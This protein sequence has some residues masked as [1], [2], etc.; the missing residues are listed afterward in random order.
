MCLRLGS[1]KLLDQLISTNQYILKVFLDENNNQ[2]LS[3]IIKLDS[4]IKYFQKQIKN[5][6]NLKLTSLIRRIQF[7]ILNYYYHRKSKELM[8]DTPNWLTMLNTILML[9]QFVDEEILVDAKNMCK[10]AKKIIQKI[11]Q[12]EKNKG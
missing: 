8:K 7:L 3:G 1:S 12:K 2:I 10:R 11:Q 5:S 6:L 9:Y 4:L